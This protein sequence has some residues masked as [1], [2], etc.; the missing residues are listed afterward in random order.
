MAHSNKNVVR[1]IL[2]CALLIVAT[3]VSFFVLPRLYKMEGATTSV[4]M[5]RQNV[6]AGTQITA[7]MLASV[8]VGSYGLDPSVIKNKE[9]VVGQYAVQPISTKD[10]LFPDKFSASAVSGTTVE[11]DPSWIE[12]ADDQ[13]LLTLQLSSTAAGAAGHILPGDLVNVAVYLNDNSNSLGTIEGVDIQTSKAFFP[14]GLQGITVYRVQTAQLVS[15]DPTCDPATST[16]ND[17]VPSYITLVCS[18][19]QATALLD[20]SY[21]HIVH[22]VEVD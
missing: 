13:V 20:Y 10:L 6:V 4:V 9:D 14:S 5:L 18:Q 1:I 2:V 17:R 22:F 19:S 16:V 7:D 11:Q 15:V 8:E 12:V 21:G 3:F